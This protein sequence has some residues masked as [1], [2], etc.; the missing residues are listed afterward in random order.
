MKYLNV[1]IFVCLFVISHCE[2]ARYDNY[3]VYKVEISDDNLLEVF[4]ELE[5][6]SDGIQFLNEPNIHQPFHIL[7]PPH[8]LPHMIELFDRLYVK[9]EVQHTNFQQ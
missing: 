7:V 4:Q 9:N 1:A 8:K 5:E 2:K 6:F 3:R